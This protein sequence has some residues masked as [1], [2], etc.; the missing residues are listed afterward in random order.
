MLTAQAPNKIYVVVHTTGEYSDYCEAVI[1]VTDRLEIAKAF[2][3][4]EA[5]QTN[6]LV[7]AGDRYLIDG[8]EILVRSYDL[9]RYTRDYTKAEKTV[10]DLE[11]K[12]PEKCLYKEKLDSKGYACGVFEVDDEED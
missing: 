11:S 7:Q 9:N 3:K 12:V 4:R 8:D 1:G 10:Y 2:A 5:D 6:E